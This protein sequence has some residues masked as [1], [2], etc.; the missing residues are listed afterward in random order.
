MSLHIETL[1][2]GKDLVLLHGWGMHGGIW[3]GV[4]DELAK[5][6]R[7]H[8]VDLPGHGASPACEPCSLERMAQLLAHELPPRVRVCG[9]SLG[10]MAAMRWAWLEPQQIERLV[11]VG[12]TPCFVRRDDWPHGMERQL[13]EDFASSLGEDH[14]ATLLRFIALQARGDEASREIVRRLRGSLFAKGRPAPD[15]LLA[16]LRI[17]LEDD[18]RLQAG[19]IRAPALVVQGDYDTLVSPAAA[20]W[21]AAHLPAARL[22]VFKGCAHAPFISHPREFI[23]TVTNFLR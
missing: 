11:L 8:V 17:L 22:H 2:A 19:E 15:A 9:W 20:E 16:G 6:F 3:D 23:E 10:G 5:N 1:G 18:L 21:L 13:L 4:A 7:V 12:A 14:E